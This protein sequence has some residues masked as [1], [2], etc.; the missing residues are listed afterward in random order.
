MTNQIYCWRT[1]QSTLPVC[2]LHETAA[3]I[4]RSLHLWLQPVSLSVLY[5][6]KDLTV[7]K[8]I[9]TIQRLRYEMVEM[10][11]ASHFQPLCERK[12]P[13]H[14]HVYELLDCL[15]CQQCD[16]WRIDRQTDWRKWLSTLTLLCTYTYMVMLCLPRDTYTLEEAMKVDAYCSMAFAWRCMLCENRQVYVKQS[17]ST[18]HTHMYTHST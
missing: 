15:N 6:G 2:F 8:Q 16:F 4:L 7:W 10:Q 17:T 14:G 12:K 3:M 9:K 11:T 13:C 5:P 1:W 18:S